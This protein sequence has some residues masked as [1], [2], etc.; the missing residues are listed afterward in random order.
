MLLLRTIISTVAITIAANLGLCFCG[1]AR[2]E[3][4]IEGE[5]CPMCAP[6]NC[7]YWHCT[8][9]TSTTCVPCPASTYTDEPNGLI[10]CFPCTV[11]DPAQH[12]KVHKA[13][14]RSA[15]TTC[16]PQEGFH[17]IKLNKGSCAL[18]VEHSACNPGQYIKQNGT[19]FSDTVCADCTD[20][21]YSDGSLMACLPHSKCET[22]G[23]TEV[24]AGTTSSD[25]ECEKVTSVGLIAGVTAAV[26][27]AVIVALLS[28]FIYRKRKAWGSNRGVS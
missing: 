5:C 19:A 20:G 18:A 11:C 13:C 23:F 15:D 7:V 24:K 8:V 6:G 21:T 22:M 26:L 25:A 28:C 12:L 3:Y 16:E 27:I 10:S 4:E 9:D 17:C 14:T 1:C 2:A